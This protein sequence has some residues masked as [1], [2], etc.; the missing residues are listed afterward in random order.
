MASSKSDCTLPTK[1]DFSKIRRVIERAM[2]AFA[3]NIGADRRRHSDALITS[4]VLNPFWE[5]RRIY[6]EWTVL[7]QALIAD[8]RRIRAHCRWFIHK[9]ARF[10]E[11]S[12][13]S[14]L[15]TVATRRYFHS[16]T[17]LSHACHRFFTHVSHT[18]RL[19]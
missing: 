8:E 10:L 15:V 11:H 6:N 13:T 18:R 9:R 1:L 16:Y 17:S 7:R 2:F 3:R 14:H 4:K 19:V 12:Y 5:R